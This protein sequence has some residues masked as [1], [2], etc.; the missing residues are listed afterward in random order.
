[1]TTEINIDYY[2][3]IKGKA[4]NWDEKETPLEVMISLRDDPQDGSRYQIYICP[5]CRTSVFN[6]IGYCSNCGQKLKGVNK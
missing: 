5:K 4:D 1:M 3:E 6:R 2:H